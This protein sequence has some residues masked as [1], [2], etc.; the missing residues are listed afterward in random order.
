M[1]SLLRNIWTTNPLSLSYP[2]TRVCLYIYISHTPIET[3]LTCSNRYLEH[4][5]TFSLSLSLTQVYISTFPHIIYVHPPTYNC[6]DDVDVDLTRHL[7]HVVTLSYA[8]ISLFLR[9]THTDTKHLEHLVTLSHTHISS[10]LRHT[11][12]DKRE[13]WAP[14]HSLPHSHTHIP[15]VRHTR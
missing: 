15:L 10:F 12:I 4:F 3:M 2:H 8:H 1:T 9:H 14:H 7:E 6:I 11:R 5:T 13:F